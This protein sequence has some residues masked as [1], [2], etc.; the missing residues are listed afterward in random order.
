MATMK[1]TSQDYI[2]GDV[3][4]V[5][6]TLTGQK[7]VLDI[8]NNPEDARLYHLYLHQTDPTKL[9]YKVADTVAVG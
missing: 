6:D 3:Y 9:V 4:V 5:L 2:T 8:Y 1:Y 7:T